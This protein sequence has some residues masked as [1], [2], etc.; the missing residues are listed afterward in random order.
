MAEKIAQD[1][2]RALPIVASGRQYNLGQI[3]LI[4]KL[5]GNSVKKLA[6]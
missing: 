4:D 5:Q 3:Y 1:M 2:T 6:R